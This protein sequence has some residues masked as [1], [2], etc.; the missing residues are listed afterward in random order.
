M[1]ES[2]QN[3]HSRVA[4]TKERKQ[5]R[6]SLF[7]R[8]AQ[9]SGNFGVGSRSA[10]AGGGGQSSS[11]TKE[12]MAWMPLFPPSVT[13]QL[14][15]CDSI[16]L[17]QTSG[18]PTAY[19]LRANDL[20]DPDFTSTGHQPMGF[21]QMMVT[22]NHFCVLRARLRVMFKNTG[23]SVCSVALRQDA[24]STFLTLPNQIRE[25][26]GVIQDQL[27]A[28]GVYGANKELAIEIDIGKLQALGDKLI[29]ANHTLRGD[30]ATSP[31]EVTYFHIQTWDQSGNSGTVSAEFILE[32]TATF[33]EPRDSTSSFGLERQK[34]PVRP[35]PL[36][37]A[38]RDYLARQTSAMR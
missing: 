8:D 12:L 20:F 36:N 27:E 24:S 13:K 28:K 30:A 15:Y 29:I 38:A 9:Q 37:I 16:S 34:E 7:M 35:G 23:S 10:L 17:S 4:S 19:V 25:F 18:V 33:F 22:Y 14:R 11:L 26:G 5:K 32:Q 2:K 6:R 3:K 31:T 21:D 1:N